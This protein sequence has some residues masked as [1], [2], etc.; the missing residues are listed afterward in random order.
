MCLLGRTRANTEE[1]HGRRRRTACL[2]G[3]RFP[4][5]QIEAGVNREIQQI[6]FFRAVNTDLGKY[7]VD[8]ADEVKGIVCYEIM[9]E[10]VAGQRRG[11]VIAFVGDN[12]DV[13]GA[14]YFL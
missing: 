6:Y 7:I 11:Y 9:Y 4:F 1:T 14:P 5:R 2:L 10:T 13:A 3:C 12:N 8:S